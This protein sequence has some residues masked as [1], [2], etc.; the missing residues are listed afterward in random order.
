MF[1]RIA[2]SNPPSIKR[3][4]PGVHH[5]CCNA[6]PVKRAQQ[7]SISGRAGCNMDG[8]ANESAAVPNAQLPIGCARSEYRHSTS[9]KVVPP[10]HFDR[11]GVPSKRRCK[12]S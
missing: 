1:D 8:R 9:W 10:Y 11:R 4:A 3:P 2:S 12:I 7:S 6:G 5:Q